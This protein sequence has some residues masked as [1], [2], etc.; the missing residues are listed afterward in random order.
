M[1]YEPAQQD[2]NPAS[3]IFLVHKLE[4]DDASLHARHSLFNFSSCYLLQL[5]PFAGR[6]NDLFQLYHPL[7]V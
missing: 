2:E 5:W 6:N 3:S 7:G 4:N 1:R